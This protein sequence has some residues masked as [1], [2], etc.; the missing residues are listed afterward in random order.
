MSPKDRETAFKRH[1]PTEFTKILHA[2]PADDA[3][4]AYAEIL[5]DVLRR[6][7]E[8]ETV[9]DS[10]HTNDE[11]SAMKGKDLKAKALADA[12]ALKAGAKG[13]AG[14]PNAAELEKAKDSAVAST[15]IGKSKRNRWTDLNLEKDPKQ[16]RA[17]WT[18]RGEAAIKKMVAH[19]AAKAPKLKLTESDFDLDFSAV[20]ARGQTVLAMGGSK[21]GKRVAVV[22]FDFV[23]T[24][25]SDPA[26]AL[27][28]VVH[29]ISGHPQYGPYGTEY[30]LALYD[31]ATKKAGFRPKI[32]GSDARREE[33]D[34]YAYQETEIYSN[35]RELPFFTEVRAADLKKDPR[36]KNLNP[37][38][39]GL[40]AD[41]IGLIKD[42]WSG[43]GLDVA[44]LRGIWSR[45]SLD[46]RI[47]PKALKAFKEGLKANKYTDAQIKEITS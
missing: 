24:V 15:S 8:R 40:I 47:D 32:P 38:P 41:H 17:D 30:H 34:A 14:V 1:Y 33:I 6:V 19:A 16:A 42:Q 27:S 21:G 35:M 31:S 29:E 39:A 18:R 13:K 2:L 12:T 5:I 43:S 36:L 23:T 9:I 3:K 7:E 25:E 20:D 46:P 11:M 45:Y 10:G 26:Y 22:G 37:D 44:M 28:T 4:G